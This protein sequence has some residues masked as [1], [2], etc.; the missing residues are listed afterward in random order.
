M[1]DY[2]FFLLQIWFDNNIPLKKL[3]NNYT[4]ISFYISSNLSNIGSMSALTAC[5]SLSLTSIVNETCFK[6]EY[7]LLLNISSY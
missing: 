1:H 7:Y 6:L 3:I 4:L 2:L 5:S